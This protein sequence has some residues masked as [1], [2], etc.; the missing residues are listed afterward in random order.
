MRKYKKIIVIVTVLLSLLTQ[1]TVYASTVS[2]NNIKNEGTPIN[3]D[4]GILTNKIT[5]IQD[6]EVNL[7]LELSL[8][9]NKIINS[10]SEILFLI[11]NS[12]SMNTVLE[13]KVTT[14]KTKVIKSTAELI[15]K[16]HTNNPEVKIG[17][18]TFS[19]QTQLVQGFTNDQSNLINA[20]DKVAKLA[21][22]GDTKMA[23]AISVAKQ[24]FS[25]NIE[26]KILVLLTDGFPTDGDSQTKAG[27]QDRSVYIISTLVGL[28]GLDDASKQKIT[29]IFG[30][31]ENPSANRFY[32]IQDSDIETTISK[33]IYNR[34]VEDFQSSINNI[35]IKDY[36]SEEIINNFDIII[37]NVSKGQTIKS[38]KDII[39]NIDTMKYGSNAILNY[40]LKLK[41]EYDENIIEKI[42]DADQK[43]ELSY[44][45]IMK[46]NQTLQMLD[47]PQIQLTTKEITSN[48][49]TNQTPKSKKLDKTT[50]SKQIPYT[51]TNT[52]IL[53]TIVLGIISSIILKRK[54]DSIK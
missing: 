4:D 38:N 8:N 48:V 49:N 27:L 19:K 30:T 34:I 21:A 41:N 13:D 12:T 9:S 43:V 42:L 15:K 36:F 23:T 28:D 54:I 25:G 32:N 46:N 44:N 29:S 7:K 45:T 47:A 1:L 33:N 52:I 11:D 24:Q 53:T 17:I 16:I 22:E 20:C 35:Q 26:N 6:N 40:T 5:S 37:N 18:M 51:G 39:W 14:R 3:T 10:N 2:I 50:V 31:K